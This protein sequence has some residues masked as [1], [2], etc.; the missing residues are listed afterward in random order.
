M[1][2]T[3]L[4]EDGNVATTTQPRLCILR[5]LLANS[6]SGLQ[7]AEHSHMPTPSSCTTDLFCRLW[8]SN[9]PF[10]SSNCLSRAKKVSSKT[11]KASSRSTGLL[12]EGLRHLGT[13]FRMVREAFLDQQCDLTQKFQTS[14]ICMRKLLF[15]GCL[16]I[17]C[18][19]PWPRGCGTGGSP[20]ARANSH[21][22]HGFDGKLC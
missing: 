15:P 9:P 7:L 18:L 6:S 22:Q 11:F 13:H 10:C 16:P 3:A 5:H 2:K 17:P 4:S 21:K 20:F 12:Q 14:R 8:W 1:V 19:C